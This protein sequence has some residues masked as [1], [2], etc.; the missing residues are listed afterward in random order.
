MSTWGGGI[1]ESNPGRKRK[2]ILLVVIG[3]LLSLGIIISVSYAWWSHIVSQEGINTIES[4]CLEIEL[5]DEN[6]I[7]LQNAYPIT[8]AEAKILIPYTFTITNTCNTAVEYDVNLDIMES[9][10]NGVDNRLASEYVAVEFNEESKKLLNTFE[11]VETSYPGSE[12]T[13]VEARYLT[14]GELSA[15]ESKTYT[16][17]LWMD[18]SVTVEDDAMNKSFISKIVITAKQSHTVR[19]VDYIMSETSKDFEK[20]EHPATYQTP[21]QTDYRYTGKSPDN[22]VCFGSEEIPCPEDN[23]YRIIGVIPTQSEVNGEYEDR[24][25]LIKNERYEETESGLLLLNGQ[26]PGVYGYDWSGGVKSNNW[27]TSTLNTEVLNKIYW[28]NLGEYQKYITSSVWYLGGAEY[29]FKNPASSSYSSE[30]FYLFERGS[31]R[32]FSGGS[33]NVVTNIG[34]MYPSDY[35]FSLSMAHKGEGL[36]P[37]EQT[38]VANLNMNYTEWTINPVTNANANGYIYAWLF[39][40]KWNSVQSA[41]SVNS[42]GHIQKVYQ[43]YIRPTF[44]LKSNVLYKN[45]NGSIE[46]PYRISINE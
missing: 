10:I 20:F 31:S 12:Y 2:K 25:K 9:K 39:S 18:E 13:P 7:H 44:Y 32:G 38:W 45:G 36:L 34:L 26:M 4:T 46:N 1:L 37:N 23:L 5:T 15:N 14:S 16:I 41:I 22:Y 27:E 6:P 21:A 17:K 35:G 28:K 3:I 33:L 24:V 40:P 8:D 19:L 43:M 11:S 42:V 29:N 30:Q